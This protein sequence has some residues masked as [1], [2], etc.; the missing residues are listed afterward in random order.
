MKDLFS[1]SR[2]FR[3]KV[4][5][6]KRKIEKKFNYLKIFDIENIIRPP[7]GVKILQNKTYKEQFSQVL[8]IFYYFLQICEVYKIFLLRHKLCVIVYAFINRLFV[9]QRI[10]KLKLLLT[11]NVIRNL[12]LLY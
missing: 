10:N 12:N 6:L 3:S 8:I 11:E 7:Y 1:S 9:I 5:K 4:R 2:N